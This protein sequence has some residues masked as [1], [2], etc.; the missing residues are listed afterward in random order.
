MR[1]RSSG[2]PSFVLTLLASRKLARTLSSP[3]K[4]AATGDGDRSSSFLDQAYGSM[5]NLS[6]LMAT[7]AIFLHLCFWMD[8]LLTRR[9]GSRLRVVCEVV[10]VLVS[11]GLLKRFV[12]F[13]VK[14]FPGRETEHGQQLDVSIQSRYTFDIAVCT[15]E[16]GQ[17][18]CC[19]TVS[20]E[21]CSS[22]TSD[23]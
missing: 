13:A 9:G 12:R 15:P 10:H 4:A 3:H 14:R 20:R 6:L 1:F 19:R 8:Q 17:W 5:F 22:S 23:C 2:Y 16:P 11:V 18:I 21:G 7:D